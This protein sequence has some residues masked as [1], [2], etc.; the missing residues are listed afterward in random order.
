MADQ[1]GAMRANL[2]LALQAAVPLEIMELAGASFEERQNAAVGA[3]RSIGEHGDQLMFGGKRGPEAFTA[4]VRGLAVLAYQPGG[5]TFADLHFCA[6]HR[7]CEAA[8]A[9]ANAGREA[10]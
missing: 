5:V 7:V 10:S 4:V 8:D 3:S 2:R 6:D 1:L 9:E